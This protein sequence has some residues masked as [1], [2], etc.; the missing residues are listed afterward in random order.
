MAL[1]DNL[2]PVPE[3]QGKFSSLEFLLLHVLDR[4]PV[5]ASSGNPSL[6]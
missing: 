5:P 4:E 2:R 3:E 1:L 6:E